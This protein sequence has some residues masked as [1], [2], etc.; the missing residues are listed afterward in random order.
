MAEIPRLHIAQD[1]AADALLA[2][3]PFALLVGMLLDQQFPM[4]RAFAG[5]AVIAQRMGVEDL[6]PRAVAAADPQ[7]FARLMAAPPAVHRYHSSMA[8]RVQALAAHVRDEYDGDASGLW[9]EAGSGAGARGEAAGPARLRGTEGP[10]LR[11]APREAVRRPAP[12]LGGGGRRYAT[13]VGV[14]R[15]RRRRRSLQEVRDHKRALKQAGARADPGG[16]SPA[17]PLR[18]ART[19]RKVLRWGADMQEGQLTGPI[20]QNPRPR[21]RWRGRSRA[22][23]GPAPRSQRARTHRTRSLRRRRPAI[24]GSQPP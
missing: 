20:G 9:R 11:R 12:G 19:R 21:N 4:E 16:A 5:P 10:H 3:D 17:T 7:E 14:G 23:A 18:R 2:R 8:G 24:S 15:R 1:E 6:D 13:P 22:A